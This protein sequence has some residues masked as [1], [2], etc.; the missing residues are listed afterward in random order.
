M[1]SLLPVFES[2]EKSRTSSDWAK[3]G[4]GR[5][6]AR[7]GLKSSLIRNEARLRGHGKVWSAMAS[8]VYLGQE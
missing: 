1:P 4:G 6:T 3:V 5:R 7:F 8:T 2:S